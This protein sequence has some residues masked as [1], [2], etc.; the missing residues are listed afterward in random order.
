M[1]LGCDLPLEAASFCPFPSGNPSFCPSPF[2]SLASIAW[3][4]RVYSMDW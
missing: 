4:D 3:S 1:D 2:V